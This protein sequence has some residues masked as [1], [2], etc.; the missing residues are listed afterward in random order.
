MSLRVSDACE[1]VGN[2]TNEQIPTKEFIILIQ[3][4]TQL[5]KPK[6]LN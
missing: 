4:P 2:D 3:E 1:N 5:N 6:R